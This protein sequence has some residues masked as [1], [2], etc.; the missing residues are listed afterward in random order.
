MKPWTIILKECPEAATSSYT[1]EA[2]LPYDKTSAWDRACNL[3]GKN[4]VLAIVPG[5]FKS[6]IICGNSNTNR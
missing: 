4:N 3:W 1:R 6:R 2:F 5:S